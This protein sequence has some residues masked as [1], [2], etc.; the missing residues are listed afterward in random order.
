VVDRDLILRRLA[1]LDTYLTQ[2]APYRGLDATEYQ[3]DWKTQRIIERTL[4]LAIEVCL[5]EWWVPQHP[6]S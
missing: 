5:D 3:R 1:L 6:R 4:H 2:L